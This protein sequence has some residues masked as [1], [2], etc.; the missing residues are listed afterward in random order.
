MNDHDRFW[1]KLRWTPL[2]SNLPMNYCMIRLNENPFMD[3]E[4]EGYTPLQW[5]ITCESTRLLAN[6]FVIIRSSPF[7]IPIECLSSPLSSHS[8]HLTLDIEELD[9]AFWTSFLSHFPLI[10]VQLNQNIIKEPLLGQSWKRESYSWTHQVNQKPNEKDDRPLC[11]SFVPWGFDI[12]RHF[13]CR[14]AERSVYG[15]SHQPTFHQLA[16][17]I[18]NNRTEWFPHVPIMEQHIA[19]SS[20]A[21]QFRKIIL[22]V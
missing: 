16:T 2:L 10:L 21:R 5:I 12:Q 17:T 8:S 11:M 18:A 14:Y 7:K 22:V 13:L 4:N 15:P 3:C 19:Q 6:P 20:V 1:N 9:S